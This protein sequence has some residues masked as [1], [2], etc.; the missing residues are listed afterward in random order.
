[1]FLRHLVFI[2]HGA[3]HHCQCFDE[4]ATKLAQLNNYVFAHDHIGHGRSEGRR[5][6]VDDFSIYLDDV[7]NHIERVKKDFKD[8]PCFILGYSMGGTMAILSSLRFP[9]VIKG[10]VLI[11]PPFNVNSIISKYKL[12]LYKTICPRAYVINFDFEFMIKDAEE[13]KKYKEDELIWKG[14]FTARFLNC[15]RKAFEA[16][17]VK[18][19][20]CPYL[21]M[22]G[23]NDVACNIEESQKFFDLSS[24]EDK[25]FKRY[26]GG[27]HQLFTEGEDVISD[28]I[29]WINNR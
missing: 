27:Y 5:M 25:T 23:S 22:H 6:Q 15:A 17:M 24:S 13:L 21:L 20:K 29:Q 28:I 19:I 18:E 10:M 3:A 26:E 11:A 12:L 14:K 16:S 7:M 9:D 8:V 2:A 1:M 4:I